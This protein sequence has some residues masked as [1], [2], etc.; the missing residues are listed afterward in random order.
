MVYSESF[1]DK[2]NKWTDKLLDLTKRNRLLN[3]KKKR[4]GSLE[5]EGNIEDICQELIFNS[6]HFLYNPV[7]KDSEMASVHQEML[8]SLKLI[9][10]NARTHYNEYGFH[11]TY[12]VF[13]FLKWRENDQTDYLMSPLVMVPVELEGGGYDIA[14]SLSQ[15]MDEPIKLNPVIVKKL[16]DDF[17]INLHDLADL[18]NFD[19][20]NQDFVVNDILKKVAD[21]LTH[22]DWSV[23][24]IIILDNFNFQ[25][26]AIYKDLENNQE[27]FS[28][29]PFISLLTESTKDKNIEIFRD[30]DSD[31]AIDEISTV[32]N[33]QILDADSSQQAAIIRARRGESFVLQGPPGTGKSQTI[34]N[35]IAEALGMGKTVLFVSE[36]QAA[37]QVVYQ[38]LKNAGLS[39][40][41][42]SLH[43]VKQS[44][45][46]IINQIKKVV[47]G[48][49]EPFLIDEVLYERLDSET[50]TLN[51]YAIEL[52]TENVNGF[53]RYELYGKISSLME[54]EIYYFDIPSNILEFNKIKIEFLVEK[55]VELANSYEAYSDE[56]R[57]S[58][59]NVFKG[60]LSL[61]KEDSLYKISKNIYTLDKERGEILQ[62]LGKYLAIDNPN[63]ISLD[64]VSSLM[65]LQNRKVDLDWNWMLLDISYLNLKLDVIVKSE[66][67]K[68]ENFSKLQIKK[69]K[70]H[71]KRNDLLKKF[72]SNLFDVEDAESDLKQLQ[73][74]YKGFYRGVISNYREIFKKYKEQTRDFKLDYVTLV[75]SLENLV[76]LRKQENDI[77]E[78]DKEQLELDRKIKKEKLEL[79]EKLE[80]EVLDYDSLSSSFQWIKDLEQLQSKNQVLT[81]SLTLKIFKESSIDLTLVK[82]AA[83]ALSRNN[84]KS[85]Q[86]IKILS[87]DFPNL[88]QQRESVLAFLDKLDF[89]N[90]QRFIENKQYKDSLVRDYQLQSFIDFLENHRIDKD[91]ITPIFK[92]KLYTLLLENIETSSNRFSK[93]RH[94]NSVDRFRDLDK[95][96]LEL[97]R[98]RVYNHLINE[99]PDWNSIEYIEEMRVLKREFNKKS[100]FIPTRKLIEKLPNLLP[101]FKPCI[102]MSPLTVSTYF[103]TNIDWE[104]DM[105]IFDEASQ[106]KPEYAIGSIARGKQLIVAGDSK[107]MPPT[108][109]F[110][111]S[112]SDDEIVDVDQEDSSELESILDALSVELPET[113]LDWHYRSKDESL[114]TFSNLKFYE[115]RLLTFPSEKIDKASSVKFSHVS[116]GIWESRNGN[117]NEAIKVLEAIIEYADNFPN[118][119][120]GVVSFGKSQAVQIEEQLEKFLEQ[121][122]KYQSYFDENKP[123]PFFIK[124]LEN[125]QGDER[126]IIIISVGYGYRPDGKIIMNFGPL[127]KSGGERRLNVAASRAKEKMHIISSI[128]SAD[129]RIDD[130][131]NKNRQVLRDFLDYAERGRDS[132]VGYDVADEERVIHFDSEFEENVYDFLVKKGYTVHTQVGDSGYKIDLAIVHPNFPGRYLLAIEC[133]GRSYHSS[134]TARDRDRLRQEILESKGWKF[135][136]I[137]SPNWLYDN[138]NE[139]RSILEAIQQA[140]QDYDIESLVDDK[141][142]VTDRISDDEKYVEDDGYESAVH[143]ETK[144][145][146]TVE[147][148]KIS[149]QSLVVSDYQRKLTIHE[150][151][152]IDICHI[153][154]SE[155]KKFHGKPSGDWIRYVNENY[156]GKKR[157]TKS[158]E[159][160]YKNA[161][162]C[163]EDS[164]LI[165]LKNGYLTG[166]KENKTDLINHINVTRPQSPLIVNSTYDK[167]AKY[168]H[169]PSYREKDVYYFNAPSRI[170]VVSKLLLT[171]AVEYIDK[172][173]KEWFRAINHIVFDKKRLTEGYEGVYRQAL[174]EL[175]DKDLVT[176]KGDVLIFINRDKR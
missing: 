12:L 57:T 129:I 44:K 112:S 50:N 20:N 118:K 8:K 100:R 156:F 49:R 148:S 28:E 55:V 157:I 35:I 61:E 51:Q 85:Q 5:L 81:D 14:Y 76:E 90:Y 170:G 164:G 161:I 160:I 138:N 117:K 43:D 60:S 151:S 175:V 109:F 33:L 145:V 134:K 68:Q 16:Q 75:S 72:E 171:I 123:E 54:K 26:F 22:L 87:E 122:P 7:I 83:E 149:N 98:R 42:L 65:E 128:K 155:A 52:N 121:N 64:L 95:K 37:L 10:K 89:D 166:L 30:Y 110:D 24:E 136:R 120:L 86:L 74:K 94:N 105:V 99:L 126:D 15:R 163:L 45:E 143:I 56:F 111:G 150:V 147:N 107:Q 62:K 4:V 131:S 70:C 6:Y 153:L 59:W 77:L 31:I 36:K 158:N 40:F 23:E 141:S 103:G 101:K 96:S 154:L 173:V 18:D 25:N 63:D 97:A 124:N 174:Q 19:E 114:I 38:K 47:M 106:V 127:T 46:I 91:S 39:D 84:E 9:R 32:E 140:I 3:Y 41:I 152:F 48:E 125:V 169:L 69:E 58:S 17:G 115:N 176:I 88:S 79:L 135:Y 102:M 167:I 119:S 73:F 108:S 104:F 172:P 139:R 2:F 132:L 29:N 142:K 27:R 159:I 80:L 66:N 93:Q 168:Y 137:W 21:K 34:T 144:E 53:S 113:H 11:S 1:K 133:D 130:T 13:G 67:T 71:E 116:N 92:R 162:V 82:K 78:I 146:D 165:T